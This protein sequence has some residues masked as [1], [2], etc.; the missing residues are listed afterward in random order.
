MAV[1]SKPTR[2]NWMPHEERL[3]RAIEEMEDQLGR[4]YKQREEIVEAARRLI[5]VY[6][7]DGELDPYIAELE[8]AAGLS[9]QDGS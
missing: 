1:E 3:G 9:Q 2:Y 7:A 8:R 4:A 5:S 6:M